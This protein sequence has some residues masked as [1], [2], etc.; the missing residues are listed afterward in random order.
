MGYSNYVELLNAK[1]YGI[2]HNRN[3]AF[4]VSILGE[5]VYSYPP[6][7]KFK[8]KL[9]DMLENE[10]DEKYWL[11]QE[12]I[13]KML[14]AKYESQ[15]IDRVKTIDS[16]T[17]NAITTMGGGNREPKI[18]YPLRSRE[19]RGFSDIPICLNSKVNGKQPSLQ[20]RVYDINGISTA[21]TT[22]FMPNIAIPQ[23]TKQG[24]ALA[25]D[26]DG[27][28]LNRP[29]QKRGVVQKGMI[30]TLKR[31]G[32]DIGVVLLSGQQYRIRKLTPK[33]CFRLMGVKDSD[34]EKLTCSNSQKYALAGNS[35]VT[36]VLMGIFGELLG[37]DYTK[38]INVV[39]KTLKGEQSEK[40]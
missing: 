12:Q 29:H 14:S 10:V 16:E 30:P 28:Y 24:F 26:G 40:T 13:N 21:V 18:A 23:A 9:K 39:L 25:K 32:K 17:I 15:S 36:T 20:D 4:M 31:Q 38:K 6:K 34:S 27:V 7:T 33:E 19:H 35:I 5:S 3:R 11:T 1:N 22:A 37:V 2:P 8:Y